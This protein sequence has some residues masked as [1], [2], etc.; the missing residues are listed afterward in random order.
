M[1]KLNAIATGLGIFKSTSIEIDYT[2][3]KYIQEFDG[4]RGVGIVFVVLAHYLPKVFIGSWVFM[5]MFFVMSG[6][7]ITG[8]LLDTKSKPG[9]YSRFIYRRT[10]R[11]F[12]LYYLSLVIL[13]FLIPKSWIDLSY[14]RE[15]QLW[16]WL[17]AENWLYAIDGW[18]DVKALHHFW[19]L[20]IEEQF[21]IIWPVVVLL[22]S[23]KNLVR[24]CIFLFFFS[25]AFRNIG[26]HQGFV[27]PFPYVATFGRMEGIVLG[28]I[29]AVLV[30]TNKS[31]LE[32]FTLPVTVISGILSFILF[33]VA[34]KM[35]FQDPIHYTVN[36]TLVDIFFAGMIVLTLCSKQLKGFKIILNQ[37]FV[38]KLGVMSYCIYI[39]HYPIQVI[40]EYNFI[41]YFHGL[42]GN[43][44]LAKLC[45][46]FI[47]FLITIP[48]VYIIHKKVEVP[49]WKLK[50]TKFGVSKG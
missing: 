36:Y 2:P 5:E 24:F 46:R 26:I 10:V 19:S 50:S 17:Y 16:Y 29:I 1:R 3:G 18:P 34:D 38:R 27:M 25:I 6:F 43:E 49:L 20:A 32:R 28:A 23:P 40:A 44:E 13:F 22:F 9:Y 30:R 45:C 21:Y 41:S 11:V 37:S 42:T 47:A 33:L 12:P 14:Y 4:W 31:V 7:L 48:V 39:F 35:I 8:I 15:H